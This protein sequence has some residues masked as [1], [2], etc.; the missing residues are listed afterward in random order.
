MNDEVVI[1]VEHVS[2]KY[3]KSLKRS[4]LYGM[5][6]IGR[7]ILGMSSH[8][9][10]LRKD[11]FWA[12]N[13]VSFEVRKGEALGIIGPNGSG[14]TTLLK[15]LN[16]IFWPDKGKITIKSKVGALIAVGAGFHEMLTGRENVYLNAAVLGMTKKEV[17]EKFDDIVEFADIGDFI[18]APVK[19]YSSGMF[20]RLGFAVAAHCDPDILLVDEVLA[21]GDTAFQRK[22]L[23]RMNNL[24]KAGKPIVFVSHNLNAVQALCNRGI[25]LNKGEVEATGDAIE[26]VAIYLNDA[27]KQ[28]A[29][30][31]AAQIHPEAWCSGE[32]EL[33]GIT[34]ADS[35]GNPTNTF[36]VGDEMKIQISYRA[37]HLIQKPNFG[38]AVSADAGT[39]VTNFGTVYDDSGPDFIEGEGVA[40]CIIEAIPFL[41]RNYS[42]S[43]FIADSQNMVDYVGISNTSMFRVE[44]TVGPSD[45]RLRTREKALVHVPARW[46]FY[47]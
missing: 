1:K 12:L 24:R 9:E 25:Y 27:N 22:C 39:R 38:V 42:L 26:V 5:K 15:L 29:E 3:C 31:K 23:E 41:P 7:N 16:G 6:D 34:L 35:D 32:V 19:Y 43:I 36:K 47:C 40:E 10:K 8:S 4:M 2:K 14:K 44:A 11:E 30:A 17:D 20:V 33:I 45:K 46:R 28:V 18:E 13:D 37:R 21:V